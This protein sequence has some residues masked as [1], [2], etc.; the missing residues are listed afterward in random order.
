MSRNFRTQEISA[1]TSGI[2]LATIPFVIK[3]IRKPTLKYWPQVHTV[4]ATVNVKEMLCY[5]CRHP[6]NPSRPFCHHGWKNEYITT[7]HTM[8]SM[9]KLASK[10]IV[11]L[12]HPV[13]Y[14]RHKW[15][16]Y[17][18]LTTS[19]LYDVCP[20]MVRDHLS[21]SRLNYGTSQPDA[22]ISEGKKKGEII[23]LPC[24]LQTRIF[25]KAQISSILKKIYIHHIYSHI[26][27][28]YD[29]QCKN[30]V[31]KKAATI[32]VTTWSHFL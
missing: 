7:K 30:H 5:A 16:C 11:C 2:N 4:L 10:S 23:L 17:V 18:L 20:E 8:S 25:Y 13:S 15:A 22:I 27:I 14:I 31:C 28:S 12:P 32:G 1:W 3:E 24:Q 21:F 9:I 6:Y 26:C 29:Y 19:R